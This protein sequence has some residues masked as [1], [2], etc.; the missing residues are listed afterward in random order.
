MQP[1]MCCKCKKNV[2]VIFITKVEN[3]VTLNEGY[4]IKCARTLGIPQIDQ[5]VKQMGI[6]EEDLDMISDEMSSMF[7]QKDDSEGESDEVDSQTATFPLMNQLFGGG[8]PK[9]AKQPENA[10]TKEKEPKKEKKSKHKLLAYTCSHD[11]VSILLSV[12]T[13]L[14]ESFA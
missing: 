9:P 10:E 6:S 2:A 13:E 8:F 11:A 14:I 12:A 3:G 4:C 7:G 1:K 5:A